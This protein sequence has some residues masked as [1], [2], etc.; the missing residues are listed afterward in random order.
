MG[1]EWRL[2]FNQEFIAKQAG[3]ASR[4]EWLED[5]ERR[6]DAGHQSQA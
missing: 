2:R 6:R 4:E 3:Y 1:D 5:M